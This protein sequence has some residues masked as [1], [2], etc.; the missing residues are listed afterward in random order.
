MKRA[1]RNKSRKNLYN[2]TERHERH[3]RNKNTVRKKYH[4]NVGKYIEKPSDRKS[5]KGQAFAKIFD[6]AFDDSCNEFFTNLCCEADDIVSNDEHYNA[7]SDKTLDS[8]FSQELWRKSITHFSREVCQ[9]FSYE[10]IHKPCLFHC[11]DSAL[12]DL[13]EFSMIS[14]FDKTLEEN[15]IKIS[16]GLARKA[17]FH[18]DINLQKIRWQ[19][20]QIYKKV[21][22][23]FYYD[24]S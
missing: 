10:K 22:A 5:L 17:W 24:D 1:R 18:P 20:E 8:I 19:K 4:E 9:N 15:I 11:P 14:A 12:A 3:L 23:E 6:E 2:K 16:K 13:I 7:I 21:F